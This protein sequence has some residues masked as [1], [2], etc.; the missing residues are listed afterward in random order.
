M[1]LPKDLLVIIYKALDHPSR[2]IFSS[3]C[4]KIYHLF[5]K[6]RKILRLKSYLYVYQYDDIISKVMQKGD[7]EV[8]N[9]IAGDI[10][11]DLALAVLFDAKSIIDLLDPKV[12]HPS[13]H[14]KYNFILS[15]N[16]ILNKETMVKAYNYLKERGY[17][18]LHFEKNIIRLRTL[19][20]II[21]SSQNE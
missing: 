8:Y 19:F 20:L 7:L 18:F 1:E 13:K 17:D 15:S 5:T 3:I 16:H 14:F 6:E 21:N 10:H 4:K 11:R 2:I 9:L 12:N